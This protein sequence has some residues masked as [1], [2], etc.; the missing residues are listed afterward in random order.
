MQTIGPSGF[1]KVRDR[2][3]E[4]LWEMKYKEIHYNK[5]LLLNGMSSVEN[6][7]LMNEKD[8]I[9]KY[10]NSMWDKIKNTLMN[11]NNS[12][13]GKQFFHLLIRSEFVLEE[14]WSTPNSGKEWRPVSKQREYL[15]KEDRKKNKL[16]C[17]RLRNE[18]KR[19]CYKRYQDA[20]SLIPSSTTTGQMIAAITNELQS[21]VEQLTHLWNN[22]L[23]QEDLTAEETKEN[24]KIVNKVTSELHSIQSKR[25]FNM[26]LREHYD[27]DGEMN[28]HRW[29]SKIQIKMLE[30]LKLKANALIQSRSKKNESSHFGN[31]VWDDDN[32]IIGKKTNSRDDEIN[33]EY[34]NMMNSVESRL[35][36]ADEEEMSKN[37]DGT[38]EEDDDPRIWYPFNQEQIEDVLNWSLANDTPLVDEYAYLKDTKNHINISKKQ[39]IHLRDYQIKAL[40][41]MFSNKR[42]RSGVIVLPCGSGKT[43]VGITAAITMKKSCLCLVTGGVS[44]EQ[45]RNEFL[46]FSTINA[47]CVCRFTGKVK[48]P[49]P[50]DGKPVIL[51]TTYTMLTYGSSSKTKRTRAQENQMYMKDI[52]ARTWGLLLCDEVHVA[53]AATFRNIANIVKCH[54]KLGLTATLVREDGKIGEISYLI[55]PKLYEANWMDLTDRGFLAR[56]MCSE[57]WCPMTPVFYREYLNPKLTAKMKAK[58]TNK[59]SGGSKG[60]KSGTSNNKFRAQQRLFVM[61]PNKV[62]ACR[63][64][65]DIHRAR[66]D[67]ILVFSDDIFALKQYAILLGIPMM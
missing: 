32:F 57:V 52:K 21:D 9:K 58:T 65:V 13:A 49:L 18:P 42:A 20:V 27:G 10:K 24:N 47:D 48:D 22:V 60:S 36:K 66:N 56:V 6:T 45:W 17:K 4:E 44:A 12:D 34:S 55:G 38:N 1:S 29:R 67:K 7:K 62:A 15:E 25:N 33:K 11:Y 28:E 35:H 39:N 50:K 46:R 8:K 54:T 16:Q 31:M 37:Y 64:L 61:N 3:N 26:W 30:K 59:V 19:M 40:S 5:M 2:I 43:L 14:P 53:P 51:I 63:Q 41:R 23:K